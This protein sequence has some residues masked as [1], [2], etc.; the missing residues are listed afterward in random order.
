MDS[1]EEK[2]EYLGL[3]LSRIPKSLK[4]FEPLEFRIPKFYDDKQHRQY[5]YVSV[6]DI[7]ILLSPT[8]R[9]DSLE[10]KYKKSSP[11]P[12]YLDSKNEE[13]LLKHTTFLKMLKEVEISE[14]EKIE[15]EQEN[16]N[17]K[18]PFKVKYESN[19]LWQIYYSEN[20]DKYFMIVPTEDTDYSTF[21]YLIKKKLS[22]NKNEKIFV[23]IR[24]VSYSTNYLKKSEFEDI[25]NY[26]WLFTKDW[27]FIYEVYDKN[28]ELSIHIVGK[29]NVYGNIKSLYKVELDNKNK[30]NQFY[31]LLKA[32]FI[33]QTD[34]PHYFNFKTNIDN[35]GELSFCFE[36]SK[37]EYSKMTKWISERYEVGEKEREKIQNLIEANINK[38]EIL[39]EEV[40]LQEIEYLAKE[41]QISTF[42]EC[43]KSFFGKVKYYFKYSKK[44]SK[45]KLTETVDK[46]DKHKVKLKKRYKD[47]IEEEKKDKYTIEELIELY[48]KYEKE[49]EKLKN[50]IMDINALK[51][52]KK[53]M[54]RKIENAKMYIEEIDK[55]KKSIF[56]FWKYS[57]KDEVSALAEGE[58]EESNLVKKITKI[59]DYNEDFE[60]FGNIMDKLQRKKL[61][62][63]E[64]DSIYITTT[65][66]LEILNKVKNN[67]VKPKEIQNSLRE[68]KKQEKE[69]KVLTENEEFDIFGGLPKDSTKVSNLASK[70]HREVPK[71]KFY[72]LDINKDTKNLEYK[73]TLEKIIENVK[74]ALSKVVLSED[75]PVYKAISETQFNKNDINV[76][77]INPENEINEILK[78]SDSTINFYKINLKRGINAISFTNCIFYDN[79]NKTLPI[80]QELSTKILVDFSKLEI[81]LKNEI[82]INIVENKDDFSEIKIRTI[83][84]LEYEIE[85]E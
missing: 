12:D 5:R 18:I 26:L 46:E 32:L 7:Q 67:E 19:Y 56:E 41:K 6:K 14:I 39:K 58:E 21:F 22:K 65:D 50:T 35:S 64:K 24:N 45:V 76:F 17:R 11:L 59:F 36:D 16:L 38:L 79:E 33:L 71:D 47:E 62:K 73:L 63:D 83:N 8:N 40:A 78:S 28:D 68:L 4:E 49:E 55:H 60:N 23:P 43:K 30:A 34:L 69:E 9:L 48:K 57:N 15:K 31:K 25:I 84:V 70:K 52:K 44:N 1:I 80:G 53:N 29:T 51:L 66:V 13:N 20:T 75:M 72:I 81:N 54:K 10:E 77:N 82:F 42:L 85:E 61:S 27:P 2:L 3:K 74:K 37:M